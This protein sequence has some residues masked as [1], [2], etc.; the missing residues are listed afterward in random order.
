MVAC[1]I[2]VSWS[3]RAVLCGQRTPFVELARH[4]EIVDDLVRGDWCCW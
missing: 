4:P 1:S 3:G 2:V